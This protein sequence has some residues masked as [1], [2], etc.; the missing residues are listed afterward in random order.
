MFAQSCL[1]KTVA[2]RNLGVGIHYKTQR[3]SKGP[4]SADKLTLYHKV[5]ITVGMPS[6]WIFLGPLIGGPHVTRQ[7]QEC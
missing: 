4:F 5:Y 7:F 1:S 6:G 3:G 2:R